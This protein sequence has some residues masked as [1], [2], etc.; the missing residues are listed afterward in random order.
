MPIRRED[1]PGP[2]VID[3]R[4]DG[5]LMSLNCGPIGRWKNDDRKM[6]SGKVLLK[7]KVLSWGKVWLRMKVFSWG[8]FL[9]RMTIFPITKIHLI[10]NMIVI[11]RQLCRCIEWLDHKLEAEIGIEM[12]W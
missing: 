4:N 10:M 8:K 9:S 11:G 3:H 6:Q 12:P 2:H 5:L 7:T 1:L